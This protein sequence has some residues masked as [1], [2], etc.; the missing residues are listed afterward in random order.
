FN[1]L[2][3]FDA[4]THSHDDLCL[5]QIHGLL[6][7]F[8]NCLRFGTDNVVRNVDLDSFD[9][10]GS[11]AGFDLISAKSTVLESDE[12]GCITGEANIGGKFALKH[13]PSENKFVA[14]FV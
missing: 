9:W 2:L 3:L 8:E 10:C 6:G 7:L 1:I 13:L 11:G 12:P 4:A 14:S 5:R